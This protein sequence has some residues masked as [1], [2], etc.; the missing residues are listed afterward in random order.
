ATPTSSRSAPPGKRASITDGVGLRSASDTA[1]AGAPLFRRLRRHGCE[2]L[3]ER[4]WAERLGEIA[5]HPRGAA[6]GLVGG[7]GA[8]G[9]A[10]DRHA[11]AV[12]GK[13]T[14]APRRFD[15]VEIR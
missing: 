9:H 6:G 8:A 13:R 15:A 10:D 1:G 2:H 3:R 4:A 11:A 5:V 12:T 7:I 14:D